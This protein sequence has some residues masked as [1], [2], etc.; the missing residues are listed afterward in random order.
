MQLVQTNCKYLFMAAFALIE[1]E[2]CSGKGL[3]KKH[4]G[5]KLWKTVFSENRMVEKEKKKYASGIS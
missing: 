4:K 5:I 1:K 2:P 3:V